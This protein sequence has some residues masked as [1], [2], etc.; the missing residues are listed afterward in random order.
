MRSRVVASGGA[1]FGEVAARVYKEAEGSF[2][3]ITRRVLLGPVEGDALAFEL[4]YFEIAP[5]GWSS[6]ERHRHPH[7][8]VVLTGRGEVRLG[9]ER[10]PIAPFD[11][12]Y[13]APEDAHQFRAAPDAKLGI[14]CVVD[15]ERDA[16][17]LID[18]G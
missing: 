14:L 13:V 9:S 11:A 1:A 7:A 17:E 6:L 12:V 5:G 8:V 10:H 15:A 3:E 2:C 18:E 16:P 4:R